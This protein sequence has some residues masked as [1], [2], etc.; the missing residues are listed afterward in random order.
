MEGRR[1]YL[2]DA[3]SLRATPRDYR[4][5]DT[6][7]FT[8]TDPDPAR[9]T[10]GTLYQYRDRNLS[11]QQTTGLYGGGPLLKDRLFFFGNLDFSRTEGTS[12]RTTRTAA[13]ASQTTG[14]NDYSYEYP[15]WLAKLDWHL[16]DHH[17]LEFTGVSDV[18]R[19]DAGYYAF[20]YGDFSHGDVQ[21][22]GVATR[23]DARL[24]IGKYTGY[25][26]DTLTLSALYGRQKIEHSQDIYNYDPTCPYISAGVTARAP[27]L[28]YGS[29][30]T[31][32]AYQSAEGAYD[33]TEGG[34][35]DLSW[36]L[37]NHE[38]RVGYDRQDAESYV[39]STYPGGYGWLYGRSTNPD[40]PINPSLGVASA[41]SA[42]GYG[43]A[44]Y[45]VRRYYNTQLARPETRQAAQY[46]EDRWQVTDTL[47]LQL[48][49]RNEQFSN[50][51]GTGEKY[52]SQRHQLAPRLG[53]VWDVH[54]D[55][56]LK[57]F[58]NAGRYH[59]ALPSNVAVRAASGSL[60]TSE[61]FTYTGVDPATGV[62]TG[63]TPIAVD[64]SLGYVCPGTAGAVSSNLECGNA[65]NPRT[66]AAINL[67]SHYQDEYI[68][69]LEQ[70]LDG[71]ANWGAKLTYREL[72]S[73]IDDTCTPTLGG[74]CFL[75]NPGEDNSFWEEQADGS[76]AQVHY[77]A[78]ELGLPKLK[79]RYYAL[80]LFLEKRTDTFYGKVAYTFSRNYGNTEGQLNSE[81]DTGSGG[82]SDVSVTQDW[83]L[84]QLMEGANGALPN[85]RAHQLKAYGY[86]QWTPEWRTGGTLTVISGRP[87]NCNSM[88][89]TPDPGLYQGAYYWY[90]GLPGSGTDPSAPGYVPPSADYAASPR[91]SHGRTPWTFDLSLNLAYSPR[92]AEGLTL[93]A[94]VMNVLNRQVAG[95]YYARYAADPYR[96]AQDYDARFWQELNYTSPRYVRLSAR[97]DF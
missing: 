78:A 55:A 6:G 94:D 82:Q 38:L 56:S 75:F 39:G 63:L 41:A 46:V 8:A 40:T 81:L 47:L 1:L 37:G 91:G 43:S 17:L 85:H 62:P 5:P 26:T 73:A 67:K 2:L 74:A 57:L 72:R 31:S 83:D 42:G 19:Y 97:Y 3:G 30:Q 23:D 80:D 77:S 34:R 69:G 89:P 93:Q 96:G 20:D 16:T 59:L 35:L 95:S 27:G 68:V 18:T 53:A 33:Q 92:W 21:N 15:R 79:R 24:Y 25:L 60:I 12:V 4:Y 9:R 76:L 84:P 10:D 11:W 88:Y 86:V 71:Q 61:Y 70:A 87:R 65:P 49:L 32:S 14:W 22:G 52:I 29:C 44:G 36:R 58:A 48:G 45:Y 28:V 54:G 13:A 90:C 66:L 51:T 64:A 50:Y 7:H